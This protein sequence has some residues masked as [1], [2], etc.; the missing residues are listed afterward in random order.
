MTMSTQRVHSDTRHDPYGWR[1]ASVRLVA[2]ALLVLLA[3]EAVSYTAAVAGTVAGTNGSLTPAEWVPVLAVF[4]LIRWVFVLPG[5]LLVLAVIE[6][7][8]RRVPYARA[9]AGVIAFAPMVA[10]ELTKSPGGFP[11]EQGAILG[12]TAVVF[13]LI[14][15]LPARRRDGTPSSTGPALAAN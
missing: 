13:A 14:A 2:N 9:L 11:S 6:L 10:W 8:A 7:L 1:G 3:F 5:L 12:V 4:L 15:R